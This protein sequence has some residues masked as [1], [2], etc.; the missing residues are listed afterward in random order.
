MAYTK[1]QKEAAVALLADLSNSYT[2][3]RELTGIPTGTLSGWA[4]QAGIGRAEARLST[5]AA[6]A[7]RMARIAERREKL[8]E[9]L[10]R[11]AEGFADRA[12]KAS[13]KG[14][15]RDAS[16][17]IGAAETA[18]KNFRLEMGEAT[19]VSEERVAPAG[20]VAA[21]LDQLAERRR[22]NTA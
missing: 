14:K 22:S 2:D 8:R 21:K 20:K 15:A 5:E 4:K 6:T 17:L 19:H 9:K 11:Y 10:I 3:V 12:S 16:L 13:L 1:E 7:A 18:L